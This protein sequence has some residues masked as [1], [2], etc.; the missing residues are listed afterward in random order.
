M[1]DT[2]Y[3]N[4][5]CTLYITHA[6]KDVNNKRGST[7]KVWYTLSKYPPI[8]CYLYTKGTGFIA[9]NC[10]NRKATPQVLAI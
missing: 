7:F 2:V 1:I 3:N 5:S 4:E 10:I 6:Y 9:R 8:S